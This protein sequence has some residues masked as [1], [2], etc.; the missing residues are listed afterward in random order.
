MSTEPGAA[1]WLDYEVN[2]APR[3]ASDEF[4]VYRLKVEVNKIGL[5]YLTLEQY[6]EEGQRLA[7]VD[8]PPLE[9][10]WDEDEMMEEAYNRAME[11]D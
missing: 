5:S 3:F 2:A 10:D 8:I 4:V 9:D 11:K 7:G 1:Q 6:F